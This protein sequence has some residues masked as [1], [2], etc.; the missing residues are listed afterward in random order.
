M[1]LSGKVKHL[2]TEETDLRW[3]LFPFF[4]L[5]FEF[6]CLTGYEYHAEQFLCYSACR[7]ESFKSLSVN[8]LM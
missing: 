5:F 7:G 6:F 1:Y 3:T 8:I 2:S 4:F